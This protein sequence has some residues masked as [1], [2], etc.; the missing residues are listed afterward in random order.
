M[1]RL[2]QSVADAVSDL[3]CAAELPADEY[4]NACGAT[5]TALLPSDLILLNDV[6]TNRPAV[7]AVSLQRLGPWWAEAGAQLLGEHPMVLSYLRA[8]SNAPRRM[9]DLIPHRDFRRSQTYARLFRPLGLRFE[10]TIL[11]SRPHHHHGRL[12]LLD[13]SRSDY[14][15]R[16]LQVAAALQPSLRL[17]DQLVAARRCRP[18]PSPDGPAALESLTSREVEVLRCLALG[19]TARQIGHALRISERTVGK[20]LQNT[21][22]KLGVSDRLLA[23][24]HA[25]RGGLVGSR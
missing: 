15:D 11:T 12:W 2:R 8:P 14:T 16:D 3:S 5:I 24:E 4:L 7:D 6:D 9:S 19:W 18:T 17:L 21:Y 13:R 20:H 22:G 1:A 23:V 10:L 25:R